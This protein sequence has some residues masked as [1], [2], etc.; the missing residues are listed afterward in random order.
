[1]ALHG[2]KLNGYSIM[3]NNDNILESTNSKPLAIIVKNQKDS[4][5]IEFSEQKHTAGVSD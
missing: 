2:H 5:S 4:L 1:M 3:I